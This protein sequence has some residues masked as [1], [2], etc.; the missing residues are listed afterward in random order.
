MT[1]LGSHLSLLAVPNVTTHLHR[2]S[3][4]IVYGSILSTSHYK[5][6]ASDFMYCLITYGADPTF[7]VA[8]LVDSCFPREVKSR[9]L[10]SDT[11]FSIAYSCSGVLTSKPSQ[12]TAVPASQTGHHQASRTLLDALQNS[13]HLSKM[14]RKPFR[15][16]FNRVLV[17]IALSPSGTFMATS[18]FYK[19]SESLCSSLSLKRKQKHGSGSAL[20]LL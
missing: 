19:W 8:A 12:K 1:A 3:G 5:K 15:I 10:L 18:A 4:H 14:M 11:A 13:R 9:L 6:V 7:L 2:I 17:L 16:N 20:S